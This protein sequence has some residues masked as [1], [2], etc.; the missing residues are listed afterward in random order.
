MYERGRTI[1]SYSLLPEQEENVEFCLKYWRCTIRRMDHPDM[2]QPHLFDP[3]LPCGTMA[4]CW[5]PF[6]CP[7]H[8]SW[9][10]CLASIAKELMEEWKRTYKD[11]Y[12][13]FLF[14]VP[15]DSRVGQWLSD[16]RPLSKYRSKFRKLVETID[17]SKGPAV[18]LRLNT[19][20]FTCL[21]RW[22][23]KY[24]TFLFS[25]WEWSWNPLL[26]MSNLPTTPLKFFGFHPI[27]QFCR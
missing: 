9:A 4:L 13:L 6:L 7:T 2:M 18:P 15:A 12:G 25:P 23:E 17:S 1:V 26:Y 10:Q 20:F 16:T 11:S 8:V 24:V 21:C 14:T 5:H 22:K 27:P 19:K 3:N